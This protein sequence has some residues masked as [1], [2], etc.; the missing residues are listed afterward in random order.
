MNIKSLVVAVALAFAAGS[1]AF[2]ADK[3]NQD[4][5]PKK[6]V[7]VKKELPSDNKDILVT[8]SHLKRTVR[9]DYRIT[10]GPSQV[11]VIDRG[12]IERSG[13]SDLKRLLVTQGAR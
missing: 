10:D 13:A 3:S 11:V 4:K 1:V 2:A 9:R 8:G 12:A 7:V 5:E 6:P